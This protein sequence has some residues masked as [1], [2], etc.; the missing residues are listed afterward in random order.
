MKQ[1]IRAKT[2]LCLPNKAALRKLLAVGS[3][4]LVGLL[5]QGCSST[6][7]IVSFSPK[8]F[9]PGATAPQTNS[10]SVAANSTQQNNSA[11]HNNSASRSIPRTGPSNQVAAKPALNKS[12]TV[13]VQ[14]TASNSV[15]S[16]TTTSSVVPVSYN[17]PTDSPQA[18]LVGLRRQASSSCN[19]NSCTTDS[20][21]C[22]SGCGAP[23]DCGCTACDPQR[24]DIDPQEYI[25][26]GGD[27]DPATIVKKDWSA[28]GIDTTDTVMYYETLGGKVCVQPSNRTCVYAPRF[29]AVRQVTGAAL[30]A[31]AL[32]P[33]RVHG[34]QA[35]QGVLD[36]SATGNM[37]LAA[38]PV[39]QK[40]VMLL[41]RLNDQ[42]RLIPID[43]IVPPTPIGT[44]VGPKANVSRTVVEENL[45]REWLQLLERRIEVGWLYNPESLTVLVGEQ[46]A[47]FVTDTK[48]AAE[49][50][51]YETPDK[52]AMRLT[53]T[54]S[55]QM[56]SPGDRI[57]F[58]VRFE[59]MGSQKLGNAVIMDSLSPRLSYIEGSQQCSVEAA[60]TIQ[61]N[62]AGSS[63]LR[64]D[65]QSPIEGQKGGVISFDCEV[66]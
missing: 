25:C 28:V 60:F 32:A 38:K 20:C 44:V 49:V 17:T 2:L 26:D 62:D 10:K 11:S 14:S 15:Q 7:G 51:L 56:A 47:V 6:G 53:K 50:Y 55:H 63:L 3:M 46:E 65:I 57:R 41:D 5:S 34:P 13:A 12:S 45:N 16:A 27:Q 30:A 54:A 21:G 35:A 23:S 8:L 42:Q 9:N 40:Q 37:E 18:Q 22:G 64:W 36:R 4:G 31:N 39:G 61:P 58:T 24:W 48:R 29:G 66:R 59:N 33:G 43:T 19:G 1:N 52:C